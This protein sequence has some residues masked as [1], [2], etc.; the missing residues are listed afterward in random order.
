MWQRAGP[1]SENAPPPSTHLKGPPYHAASEISPPDLSQFE[2]R[3]SLDLVTSGNTPTSVLNN[4]RTGILFYFPYVPGCLTQCLAPKISVWE[5]EWLLFPQSSSQLSPSLHPFQPSKIH[6]IS[7]YL[8][9]EFLI[10]VSPFK[11]VDLTDFLCSY[12]SSSGSVCLL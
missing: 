4:Y 10:A 11:S 1:A 8:G 5:T 3:K 12:N 6:L 2:Q 7:P 9:R